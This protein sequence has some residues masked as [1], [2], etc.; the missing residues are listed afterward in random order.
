MKDER[1]TLEE[2]LQSPTA[3]PAKPRPVRYAQR[4]RIVPAV[5]E[6]IQNTRQSIYAKALAKRGRR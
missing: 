5:H 3:K 1:A 6:M 2:W 4:R